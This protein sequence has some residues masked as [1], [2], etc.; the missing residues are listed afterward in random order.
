MIRLTTIAGEDVV[1]DEDCLVSVKRI[2]EF[3]EVSHCVEDNP[4]LAFV[5]V[6]ETP[7]EVI[8]LVDRANE[9]EECD[10]TKLRPMVSRG[11]RQP[12]PNRE[13]SDEH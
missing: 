12:T 10:I 5:T 1:L 3:T 7:E 13:K 8:A 11:S 6:R 2:R 4:Y 9:F